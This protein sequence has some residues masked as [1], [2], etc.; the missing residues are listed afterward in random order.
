MAWQVFGGTEKMKL[1]LEDMI[2]VA[3]VVNTSNKQWP[4]G[5][6]VY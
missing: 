4:S 6:K 1:E 3:G 5:V 2:P